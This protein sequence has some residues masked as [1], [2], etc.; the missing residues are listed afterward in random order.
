MK[1]QAT[2]SVSVRV[3]PE[4]AFAVFTEEID[5]WWRRGPRFRHGAKGGIVHLEGRVGGRVFESF[6]ERVVE[7]G[8]LTEWEPPRRF[9]FDWRNETFTDGQWTWVEVIFAPTTSGTEV[10]VRHGGWEAIPDDHPARHGMDAVA[11]ARSLGIWW[12]DQLTALRAL[13]HET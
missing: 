6:D 1:A 12:G 7:V 13:A 5:R 4:V 10:T 9:K 2:A 3:P 11:F 8:R